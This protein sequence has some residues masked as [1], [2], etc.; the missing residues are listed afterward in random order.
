V[1]VHAVKGRSFFGE[2]KKPGAIVESFGKQ[3]P[4]HRRLMSKTTQ[5]PRHP[6]A[7]QL[8]QDPGASAKELSAR[9]EAEARVLADLN[10]RNTG[11]NA[12]YRKQRSP[13]TPSPGV[14]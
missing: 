10:K 6:A 8:P 11:P 1:A 4:T 5:R 9:A 14:G 2:E 12:W 13:P 7:Q 3:K